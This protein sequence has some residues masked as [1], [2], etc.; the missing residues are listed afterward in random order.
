MKSIFSRHAALAAFVLFSAVGASAQTPNFSKY[1]ALGDSYGAGYGAGCLVAR[2]QR[3]SYPAQLAVAFGITGFQQPTISDPG[4]PTCN[5]LKSLA[6]T[7]GPI[8][9]GRGVPTN[10]ALARS[11]DNLSVPGYKIADVSDKATDSGGIADVVLRGKGTALDQALGLNPTFITLG[12]IG[13]DILTVGG[14]AFLQDGV[15][16]TPMP[17]FTAKYNAVAA[18]LKANGRTGVFLGT[19]NLRFIPLATTVPPVVVNPATRQPVLDATG[20]PIPLF[21]PR[22]TGDARCKIGPAGK[23]C[24]LPAGTLVTLGAVA[25]QAALGGS[26]LL[27]L[28]FGIPCSVNPT[29]ARCDYPLPDGS[30]TPPATVNL[31]VLLYPDEVQAI[32]Q[33]VKDMNVVIKSA[34]E[35]NGFKYFDFYAFSSDLLANGRT[36]GGVHVSTAFVSGGMFAYGDAVHMS[37]I[38]YTILADELVQFIN[39]SY[40]T[41]LER[42][43]VAAALFTPDVPAASTAVITDLS[44][45]FTEAVWR[46]FF[47]GYNFGLQDEA[48]RAVLPGDGDEPPARSPV[49]RLPRARK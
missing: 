41:D 24:P 9:T 3:F 11:Y 12:I 5:E 13:N 23:V 6:P 2:E 35:T 33:R 42:P 38:G 20:Q 4:I 25:P 47:K 39:S 8:S 46:D 40:G 44:A 30:F 22:D 14:A 32:D 49:M 15:T 43:N 21:G 16:A 7:F 37:N 48:M 36:Y 31:G 27:G 17:V 1:V 34:A 19:P 18:A 10:A 28:G 29:L 45:T 26:S